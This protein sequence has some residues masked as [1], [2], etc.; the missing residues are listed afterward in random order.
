MK[1]VLPWAAQSPPGRNSETIV[2][3]LVVLTQAIT[4][5]SLRVKSV[6][7]GMAGSA[8]WASAAASKVA[9]IESSQCSCL[10]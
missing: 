9:I 4:V 5:K 8:R 2:P 7:G 1:N 3:P 10:T 6:S